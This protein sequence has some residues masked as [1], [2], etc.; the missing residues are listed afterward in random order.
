VA[1]EFRDCSPVDQLAPHVL[2]LQVSVWG[3]RRRRSLV[4]A[5]RVE[6]RSARVVEKLFVAGSASINGWSS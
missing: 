2:L 3:H 1:G 4:P 5:E 6:S